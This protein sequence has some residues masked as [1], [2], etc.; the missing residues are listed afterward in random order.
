[1]RFVQSLTVGFLASALLVAPA[2]GQMVKNGG[3]KG[4]A[5]FKSITVTGS[6]SATIYTVPADL[7]FLLATF[8]NQGES[9]V[10][11]DGNTLGT[12]VSGNHSSNQARCLNFPSGLPIPAGEELSCNNGT[13]GDV[14][15]LVA[16]V[17]SKK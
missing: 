2:A 11:L 15:C 14:D 16:G 13:S 8:C 4:Y 6:S 7:H 9:N 17:L 1:M 10:S 12:I 5:V 3:P